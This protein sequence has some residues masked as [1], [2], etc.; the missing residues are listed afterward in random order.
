[1][2]KVCSRSSSKRHGL[3]NGLCPV[4]PDKSSFTNCQILSTTWVV[5]VVGGVQ[6]NMVV[7]AD[8]LYIKAALKAIDSR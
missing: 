8:L 4:A 3:Y 5:E 6:R 7:A 2:V 1:M